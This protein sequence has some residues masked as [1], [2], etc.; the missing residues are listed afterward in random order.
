MGVEASWDRANRHLLGSR[1]ACHR[2][3][4]FPDGLRCNVSHGRSSCKEELI[5]I[6]KGRLVKGP[7]GF[8]CGM[9]AMAHVETARACFGFLSSFCVKHGQLRS[10]VDN[11]GLKIVKSLRVHGRGAVATVRGSS[12]MSGQNCTTGVSRV[13]SNQTPLGD[14]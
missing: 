4:L 14:P 11:I 3:K 8:F 7:L 12:H 9:S 6:L 5:G 10:G 2:L 13:P 1:R